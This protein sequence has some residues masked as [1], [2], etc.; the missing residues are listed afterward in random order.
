MSILIRYAPAELTLEQYE[1]VNQKL[2]AQG[3]GEPPPALQ[4]HVLFETG[5]GTL[6]ISEIW[7]SEEAWREMFEGPLGAAI[8]EVGA[9]PGTPQILKIHSL[10]GSGLPPQ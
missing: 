4:V 1:A 9:D 5:D 6:L 8:S 7:E 10:W 2:Q 3:S